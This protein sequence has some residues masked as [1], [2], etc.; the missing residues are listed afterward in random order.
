MIVLMVVV[1]TIVGCGGDAEERATPSKGLTSDDALLDGDIVFQIS[2][3]PRSE[4]IRCATKS[5]WSHVGL[6]FIRNGRPM[7]LEAVQP[8]RIVPLRAWIDKGVGDEFAVRRLR[9][10]DA[11]RIAAAIVRLD[12]PDRFF[13][14]ADYD[15]YYEWSDDRI[16]CSELVWK[17]YARELGIELSE[18]ERLGDFDLE[19]EEVKRAIAELWPDGA[20]LDM[21]VVSPQTLFESPLLESVPH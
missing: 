20:P 1:S 19:C 10:R 15:K 2:T 8:V 6:V 5:R 16:Y 11:D 3:S 21:P 7:V 18:L 12:D 13:L 14:G 4:A 17:I 9:H